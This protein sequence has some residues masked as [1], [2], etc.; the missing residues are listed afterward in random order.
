MV[1]DTSMDEILPQLNKRF[2]K[3]K[4]NRKAV[5]QKNLAV[6][7]LPDASKV[8]I[9]HRRD[10]FRASRLLQERVFANPKIEVIWNKVVTEI[11]GAPAG[12][13]ELALKDTATGD[14]SAL[15]VGG[16][17]VFIG[18]TPNSW[19]IKDH[20]EHD[21]AG[22]VVTDSTMQTSNPGLYAAGDLRVQVTRQI[23]TA[24]GDATTA[25]IAIEKFLKERTQELV[26]EPA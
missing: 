19:L 4:E 22:Y 6:V 25:V 23:T 5:P 24:V 14:A 18:F 11:K 12:V 7:A 10:E 17:F 21:D 16:I 8:Y 20:Y 15:P 9:I 26:R 13:T 1:G 3:W 2:G